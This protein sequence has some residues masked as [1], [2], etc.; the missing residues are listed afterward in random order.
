MKPGS[1]PDLA[2]TLFGTE[3]ARRLI[4]LKAA[5]P[6]AVGPELAR[7]SE[8][9]A[10]DGE[11][12]RIRVPDGTWRRNLWRMR[13]ELLSRLR[14]VAGRAAPR[15][16]GFVEGPVTARPEP[17]ALPP[18]RRPPAPLPPRVAA[19]AATIEDDEIRR[20]FEAAARQYFGRFG[21]GGQTTEGGGDAGSD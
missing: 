5:W 4:L 15:G 14:E 21:T 3:P 18:G 2:A 9:V 6:A 8:A 16:L 10:L 17:A 13:A 19:A 1:P 12:L 7:R 20:R 11:V